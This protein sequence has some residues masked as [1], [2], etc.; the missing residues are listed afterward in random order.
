MTDSDKQSPR[1]PRGLSTKGTRLWREMHK[2]FSAFN[3]AELVLIEEAC[4]IA[5][6]LDRLN[7]VLV[8]DEDAFAQVRST[9]SDGPLVLVVNDAMSEAR[10]QANVLKQIVAALRLP[11]EESGRRPIQRN[12]GARGAHAGHSGG[13]ATSGGGTVSAIEAA[14]AARGA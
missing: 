8:G 7:G 12:N 5:D 6:R 9:G 11:D 1:V 10:Q 13:R 4:R 14:R 3:P 2:A